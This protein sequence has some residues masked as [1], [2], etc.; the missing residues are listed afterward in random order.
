MARNTWSSLWRASSVVLAGGWSIAPLL[1]PSS[2]P[3]DTPTV[4]TETRDTVSMGVGWPALVDPLASS[5]PSVLQAERASLRLWPG[6]VPAPA[7]PGSCESRLPAAP[8][9]AAAPSCSCSVLIRLC[10]AAEQA[11]QARTFSVSEPSA[12]PRPPPPSRSSAVPLSF[13]A[14]RAGGGGCELRCPPSRRS[15]RATNRPPF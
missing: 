1:R 14:A 6:R 4:P 11:G 3:L 8:P 10:A 12:H 7:S 13:S 2:P 15:A 9:P 5:R